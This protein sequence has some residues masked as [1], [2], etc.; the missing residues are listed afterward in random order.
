MTKRVLIVEDDKAIAR[1]LRDN[2]QYE[3]FAIEWSETGRDALQKA[4]HFAPDLVL[5]DLMLPQ[6]TDGLELCRALTQGRDHIPVI[7]LTARGQKEDRVRGLTL[8]ADTT[9]S[10]RSRSMSS[11]RASTPCCGARS[12]G[13][14]S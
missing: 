4:K 11:W 3:G 10:S 7:I 1:L 8:G 9:S 2:L 14:S 6:G 12:R 13:S 5:L